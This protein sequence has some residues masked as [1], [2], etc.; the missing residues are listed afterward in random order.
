MSFRQFLEQNRALPIT[1]SDTGTPARQSVSRMS[2]FYFDAMTSVW[3]PTLA[4]NIV[5]ADDET[6]VRRARTGEE[7]RRLQEFLP[8]YVPQVATYGGLR[9]TA[10]AWLAQ[11]Q[12][13]QAFAPAVRR[14]FDASREALEGGGFLDFL[15]R[16]FNIART[17][18]WSAPA[19]TS[20]T[21]TTG[22]G[23]TNGGATGNG[24]TLY[25]VT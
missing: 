7:Q 11:G 16:R 8:D 17:P 25:G 24:D 15:R 20:V 21:G 4:S 22:A 13:R 18:G 9:G 14:R 1:F 3:D 19:N 23:T 5:G 12:A 2:P 6:G 10:P